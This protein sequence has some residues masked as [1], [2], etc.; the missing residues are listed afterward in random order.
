MVDGL[1]L[2]AWQFG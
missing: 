1:H 2:I